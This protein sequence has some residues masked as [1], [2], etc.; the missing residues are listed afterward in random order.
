[1]KSMAS[2]PEYLEK[3][4]YQ[5]P[6]DSEDGP[7][8]YGMNL[9]KQN[10]FAVMATRPKLLNSFST[11]FEADRGSRPNWVD[12]FPVK[13]KLLSD[14][15]KPVTKEDILY[16]DVAGGRGHDLVAFKKKFPDYPGRY[17]LL[18]L[19]YIVED[20]T[21][22]LGEGVQKKAFNFFEDTVVPGKYYVTLKDV[23]CS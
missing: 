16:V 1:M 19:P 12:W 3:T 15:S 2:L 5:N 11:F 21:I 7:L 8:Q 14:P 20:Q 4:G 10:L 23:Y 9:P 22:D 13:Q 18:D 17:V 6:S